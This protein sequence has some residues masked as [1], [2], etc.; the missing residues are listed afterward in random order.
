M[1]D[2]SEKDWLTVHQG[3]TVS[4]TNTQSTTQ[5]LPRTVSRRQTAVLL[6]FQTCLSSR[7][8]CVMWCIGQ[9]T[10]KFNEPEKV[11]DVPVWT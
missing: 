5:F 2:L 11:P 10:R 4:G 1:R 6:L 3:G 9:A 8:N 7:W